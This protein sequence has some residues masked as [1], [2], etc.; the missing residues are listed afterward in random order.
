MCG[1]CIGTSNISRHWLSVFRSP[2]TLLCPL[3]GLMGADGLWLL[4]RWVPLFMEDVNC[5][6]LAL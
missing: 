5:G 2:L 6:D 1:V 3:S 4:K